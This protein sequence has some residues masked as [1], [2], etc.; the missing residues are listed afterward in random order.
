MRP[1][2]TANL[3][4]FLSMDSKH[5]AKDVSPSTKYNLDGDQKMEIPVCVKVARWVIVI[6]CASFVTW[7]WINSSEMAL[8][9]FIAH[10]TNHLLMPGFFSGK[11]F[12]DNQKAVGSSMEESMSKTY[13]S[14]TLCPGY[15][16]GRNIKTILA[17]LSDQVKGKL[18]QTIILPFP[19]HIFSKGH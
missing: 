15:K 9:L 5:K 17:D 3:L 12:V 13:P 2:R 19:Y 4:K 10:A 16:P 6:A 7:G 18:S 14:V 1:T 8:M 11:K